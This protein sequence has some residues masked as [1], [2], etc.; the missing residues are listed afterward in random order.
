MITTGNGGIYLFLPVF[1]ILLK[2]KSEGVSQLTFPLQNMIL[3]DELK[4]LQMLDLLQPFQDLFIFSSLNIHPYVTIDGGSIGKVNSL[5]IF[6]Y[7]ILE[8]VMITKGANK[9]FSPFPIF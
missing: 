7:V 2:N 8:V 1:H 3:Q 6:S 9:L 5:L 4:F